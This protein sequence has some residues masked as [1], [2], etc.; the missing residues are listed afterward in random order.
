[1]DRSFAAYSNEWGE[2]MTTD[3]AEEPPEAIDWVGQPLDCAS[4]RNTDLLAAARCKPAHACAFDR[5]AKRIARFFSWNPTTADEY[6][7]HPYFEVRAIIARYVNV[8]NLQRL[9]QDPDETVR[10]SAV[11][12]L[13]QAQLK[14]LVGD[15]D[16]EV[17]IRVAQRLDPSELGALM[18]D[19]DYFVRS[20]VARRL[21]AGRLR[22]MTIDAD[23][24]VR[25]QVA[26]RID[27]EGLFAMRL[28]E[29]ADVRLIVAQRLRSSL[30][31]LL[32]DDADWRVRFEVARRSEDAVLLAKFAADEDPMVREAAQRSDESAD[33]R[34]PQAASGRTSGQ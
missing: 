4:C 11:M 25:G 17:R 19:T 8:F 27:E 5:Y 6:V 33:D 21:P 24:E 18:F 22:K 34:P 29:E 2:T 7:H 30:L 32:A 23:A 9:A 10:L 1:M 12:R 3:S 16:R 28:D 14:K 20:M 13:P 31:H 26:K 15:P